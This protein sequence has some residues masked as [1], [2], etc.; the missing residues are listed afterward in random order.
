MEIN[1]S[2]QLSASGLAG[3]VITFSNFLKT[4]GFKVFQSS[5]HDA[6]KS[7]ETIDLFHKTDFLFALRS[8]LTTG[9]QEWKKFEELFY[10]F[11]DN[12]EMEEICDFCNQDP[13][14]SQRRNVCPVNSDT[15]PQAGMDNE[16]PNNDNRFPGRGYSPLPLFETKNFGSFER[17]DVHVAHLALKKIAEPFRLQTYRHV[18]ISRRKGDIFFPRI[19]RESL[20]TDGMPVK[21]FYREKKRR[22]KRL[23]IIADVSG[24][25]DR[26]TCILIPFILGLKG[27]GSRAEAFV[28]STVLTS[29][30]FFIRHFSVEE[31]LKKM[32]VEVPDW[33][34]GTNIGESLR[35][36]NRE[37]GQRLLNNRTVVVILSDGWDLWPEI[38]RRELSLLSSKVHRIIWLNPEL[39]HPDT[40]ITAQG[41]VAALPY[42]DYFMPADD[43]ESLKRVGRVLT[44]IMIH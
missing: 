23:V 15:N 41:M 14:E 29:V 32:S 38:L 6:L 1:K 43:L 11:W 33:S 42:I 2:I 3:R 9:E 34:G 7:L 18:R 4:H 31:A 19:M 20:K 25:M 26:Y 37:H 39:G 27:I 44:Q 24:S 36:F 30:T 40:P 35:Q 12:P 5:V 17:S 8:N 28:F 13:Q 10:D 21:L 16:K 22:L